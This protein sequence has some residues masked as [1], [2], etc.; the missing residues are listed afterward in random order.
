MGLIN[1]ILYLAFADPAG[2]IA[3]KQEDV[4]AQMPQSIQEALSKFNLD[5]R[6][7]TYAVCPACHC[8]YK[9]RFQK[10]SLTPIYDEICRN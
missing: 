3:P 10:G 9:P 7:T 4:I 2:V 8:T 1:I 5:S 6:T